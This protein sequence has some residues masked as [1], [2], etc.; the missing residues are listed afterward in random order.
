MGTV[1]N[2][3]RRGKGAGATTWVMVETVV[4]TRRRYVVKTPGGKEAW[5]LD[6]VV[7]GDASPVSEVEIGETI[8]SSRA[9]GE[10]DALGLAEEDG[11]GRSDAKRRFFSPE[12]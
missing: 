8:V 12:D 11:V 9:V 6:T 4:L 7:M 2:R 5:A 3:K 1:D 10:G